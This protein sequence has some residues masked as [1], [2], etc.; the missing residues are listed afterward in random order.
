MA[1]QYQID[2]LDGLDENI[3]ALYS[4]TDG[5]FTLDVQGHEKPDNKDKD[6]KENEI[7]TLSKLFRD[8]YPESAGRRADRSYGYG[9]GG[10]PE[11]SD[12]C[13][14]GTTAPPATPGASER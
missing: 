6:E 3:A 11:C 5:K 9:P 14:T 2:T 4:E 13:R 7:N 12:P 8:P 1:L 10:R